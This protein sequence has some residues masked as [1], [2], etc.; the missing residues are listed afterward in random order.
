MRLEERWRTLLRE[1]LADDPA[2]LEL[3]VMGSDAAR[4]LVTRDEAAFVDLLARIIPVYNA[5]IEALSQEVD[6]L[7]AALEARGDDKSAG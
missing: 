5:M 4:E 2:I 6:A 1:A 3:R 7:R